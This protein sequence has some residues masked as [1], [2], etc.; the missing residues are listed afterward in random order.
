MAQPQDRSAIRRQRLMRGGLPL[1]ALSLGLG[2]TV[3]RAQDA[4]WLGVTNSML[5]PSNWSINAV[6]TAANDAIFG[7]TGNATPS[8]LR[9]QNVFLSSMRF[10][11]A[12][13]PYA[14]VLETGNGGPDF[15]ARLYL[16]G[17]GIVNN[18]A[19]APSFDL[20]GAA[21]VLSNTATAAN[22]TF[23]S[24]GGGSNIQFLNDTT[25]AVATFNNVE[26]TFNDNATAAN[27]I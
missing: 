26:V 9:D 14:F 23:T 12:A 10:D 19:Q 8:I 25:A 7:A 27:L 15:A 24:S 13:Q 5:A 11:A 4:L 22:A 2:G 20:R 3:A 6:P 16:S 17:A 21:F 18:A 1:L